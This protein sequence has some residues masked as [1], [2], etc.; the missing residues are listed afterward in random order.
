MSC[1]QRSKSNIHNKTSIR[2][3]NEKNSRYKYTR[4]IRLTYELT[5]E[6]KD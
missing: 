5:D 6:L 2:T 3:E 4:I 1:D